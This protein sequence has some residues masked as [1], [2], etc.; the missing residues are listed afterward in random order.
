MS[1]I[2]VVGLGA[3]GLPM[4]TNLAEKF[5]VRGV[6]IAEARLELGKEAG[7]ETYTDSREAASGA[8]FVLLA[9]RSQAQLQEALFGANGIADVM[10]EGSCVIVTSTVGIDAIASVVPGLRNRGI[11]LVDAPVSGGPARAGKGD[12]LVTVGADDTAWDTAQDVLDTMASTLVRV[13]DEAGKGQAMKTVN[14]L[15]CG[16]HIA[17]AGEALALAN[18]LGLDE[19]A[20]L[21]ALMSGAA[22]SFMLGDRGPR[23]L[24]AYGE[25]PVEVKSRLDIF[26]KDMGIVTDAA[27]KAGIGVPLAAAAEQ[28]YLNGLTRRMGAQDDS[29]VIRLVSPERLDG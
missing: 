23:M 19:A 18:R 27:R 26:V 28:V 29:S 7:L 6:D 9:V 24:Q 8:D 22:S 20:A 2:T 14:Q 25:E 13:G 17:A 5:T 10:S 12:L 15:L 1:T 16:I 21:D 3:M 4:A 11:L